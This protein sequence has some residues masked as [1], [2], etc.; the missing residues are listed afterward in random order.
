MHRDW[1]S[2]YSRQAARMHLTVVSGP[3]YPKQGEGFISLRSGAPPAECI[4]REWLERGMERAWSAP[5]DLFGYQSA[6]GAWDLR[7]LVAERMRALGCLDVMPQQ[8]MLLSGAQQG[9]DF[10]ARLFINPGDPVAI[11][12]PVY[13]GALQTFDLCAPRYLPIP[14]GADGLDLDALERTLATERPQFLYTVPTFQNPTGATMP[15]E[16]RE[17]LVAIARAHGLILIEDDPYSA[18]RYAGKDVPPLRALDPEV[19]YLGTFSKTIAPGIRVG[20]MVMPEALKE[21]M[22]AIKEAADI[23]S[24]RVMQQAVVEMLRTG[25]FPD[26]LGRIRALYAER[27]AAMLAALAERMPP[28][29]RWTE[30]EGGFFVWLRLPLGMDVADA[31]ERANARGVGIVPG[32]GCTAIP[33]GQSDGM[34]LSFCAQ[35]PDAITEGIRRL[36]DVIASLRS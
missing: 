12:D 23:N 25:F 31:L 21:K 26:H 28:D 6:M 1:Q 2:H 20:W 3:S 34:R 17:R 13:P 8:V 36:A 11:E 7:V 30:P 24:D 16:R 33:G 32:T 18:L 10:L 35:P 15:M 22:Y 4:P 9:I 14:V 29:V 27:R 5:Q 19:I